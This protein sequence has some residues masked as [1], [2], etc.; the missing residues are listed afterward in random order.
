MQS[1]TIWTYIRTEEGEIQDQS[2]INSPILFSSS[3]SLP[4]RGLGGVCRLA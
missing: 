3:L 1:E 4:A 2:D